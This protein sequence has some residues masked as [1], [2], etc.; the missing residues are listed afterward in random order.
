MVAKTIGTKVSFA[1]ETVAGKRPTTGYEIW[2]DCTAHPDF[3]PEADQI[4]T[5]TLCEEYMHTYEAGLVDFG[6]LAFGCNLTQSTYDMMFGVGGILALYATKSSQ[7][8]RLWACV[9]IKGFNKSFFVPVKPQPNGFGLPGG[10]AGS[11]KYDLEVNFT[12]AESGTSGAD[13]AGWYDDPT[14]Q[15]T[16]TYTMNISG[17][18]SN[19]VDIRVLNANGTTIS[20]ISTSSATT[21]ITLP[22]G[23]YTVLASKEANPTQVKDVD[24]NSSSQEVVFTEFN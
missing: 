22:S 12:P 21:T 6:A 16:T 1:W 14:Y 13:S 17:Y 15:G 23:T 18:V 9:D 7:N 24:L 3:N 4:E 20:R 8:L 10:E 11:N 19:E 5:T 2:C